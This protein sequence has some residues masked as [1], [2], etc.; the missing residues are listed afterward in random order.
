MLSKSQIFIYLF[1]SNWGF[2][3]FAF[4]F[5]YDKK[6]KNVRFNF[7]NGEYYIGQSKN[8]LRH[9]KGTEYYSNGKIKYKG[10]WINDKFLVVEIY[11]LLYI[12]IS[13]NNKL[14]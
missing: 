6:E 4:K 13:Y 2:T 14:K 9:G 11:F 1:C 7:D 10:D 5:I 3:A 12:I 8:G